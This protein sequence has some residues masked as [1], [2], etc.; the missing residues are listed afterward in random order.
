M[1]RKLCITVFIFNLIWLQ[2]FTQEDTTSKQLDEVIITSQR[3]PQKDV[4]VPYSTQS[5]SSTYLE[6]FQPRTT[7]EALMGVNG[8]F[9]Q[10]TNHGGGS[11]FLRGLTGNQTLIL[12]DGIRLNNSTFR[13]GPNQYLNTIDAY[14]INKIEVAKGTGSVQYGSDAIG[15]V[16]QVF[17]KTPSFSAH[18][19]GWSGRV[20][21]KYMTGDMEKTGRG[22]A[23]Y[24]GEKVA[25]SIGATYRNFGD[26]VGGDTTGKQSPSGYK[27]LAFDAKLKFLLSSNAVL[28]LAS[29]FL[30]QQHVPVYHKVV[31][32]NFRVNEFN[33]QQRMLNYARLNISTPN[34]LVNNIET[35]VSWQ[36]GIEGRDSRKNGTTTLRKERDEVNTIGFTTDISSQITRN[37]S[38]N[39]GVEI[40][41][42]RVNSN[43]KIVNTQTAATSLVRGL[44]PDNS[45]NGNYALY[46][47]HHFTFDKWILESGVRYNMFSISIRDTTLGKV[48]INPSSFVYNASLL[49]K[50][51]QNQSAFVTFNTG[52]RAPNVDD[53]G[54][55]GI[56][57][58][59]Y[60]VPTSSLAP[61]RS[62]NIE[63][64]YKV[65]S[66][67]WV[68]S[69]SGYYMHLSNLITR[70]KVNGEVINGYQV[71]RKENME[72]GYIKGFEAA[73]D[74]QVLAGLFVK[75]NVSYTFG[76]ALTRNEP[77]RRIPPLN[78]RLL[79]MYSHRKWSASAELLFASKQSRL[80]Q[81]DK[82]DNRIPKGGTPGWNIFNIYAGYE[83]K[84][85]KLNLGVQNIFNE[86][87]RTHGSGIN[88]V[89]RSAWLS[90][91]I[92]L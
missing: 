82:D 24:S 87:Y 3:T 51:T 73:L 88:G 59:R 56:V 53:M 64:G 78:G 84:L 17:T 14:T 81:G 77:L 35:I 40:Y 68:G 37:W 4:N 29:Q 21:G 27:E 89:G 46:S 57:D 83:F 6:N 20:L 45:R 26:L 2:A 79:S 52:F 50:I 16:L 1:T 85:L 66:E 49:Y 55:L 86:D 72:S 12:V 7:P 38:A 5:V 76:Q 8:V 18:K 90:L 33:P 48:R 63:L 74:Y 39:S 15:G 36:K 25:A 47:L 58:F 67:K 92:N 54:T 80:A 22:E 28:T 23:V 91:A 13:Y 42:D 11:P 10:K 41:A 31:L 34:R 30:Q 60:E 9:I 70:V 19:A 61:E 75:G 62:R 44:Y 69:L 32:E 43:T 65:R 71:Y